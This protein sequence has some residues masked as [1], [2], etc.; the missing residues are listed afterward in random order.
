MK[1]K[2][3]RKQFNTSGFTLVEV[4]VA[5]VILLIISVPV[6]R[7]FATSAKTNGRSVLK[8]YATNAAEDIME[9]I[10]SMDIKTVVDTFS[11]HSLAYDGTAG[12][13]YDLV[14]DSA[15][16]CPYHGTAYDIDKCNICKAMEKDM[17]VK[18]SLDPTYY[19]NSNG[20][21]LGEY[22]AVSSDYSAIF[23]VPMGL[24]QDVFKEFEAKSQSF[25]SLQ[26][27]DEE[28][29]KHVK[30]ALWFSQNLKREI[31]IDVVSKGNF[32]T[33]DGKEYKKAMVDVRLSYL[34]PKAKNP[35]NDE[36]IKP[37][38]TTVE[39]IN[40]QIFTNEASEKPLNS[41]FIMYTPV[42]NADSNVR[43]DG[44]IIIV[45][46]NDNV[47][48]NLYIIAQDAARNELGETLKD[49]KGNNY[50]DAHWGEYIAGTTGL[51]L[52]IYENEI[53]DEVNGGTKQ[54][55]TLRTN[56]IEK[57][58]YKREDTSVQYPVLC[59]MNVGRNASDPEGPD[60]KFDNDVWKRIC[61]KKGQFKK[62]DD[63][64][65]VKAGALDGKSGDAS[66][67]TDRIY[68][69]SVTVANF[70]GTVADQE[71]SEQWP[72]SVTLTSSIR[73]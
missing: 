38:D 23:T 9:S 42:T 73:Q 51:N 26:Y 37:S 72:V 49:D 47:E 46:N 35:L 43:G 1:Q 39:K 20:I 52:Q 31:R 57:T 2:N 5:V 50:Y 19:E 11:I 36:V 56:L 16:G 54:P 29:A 18:I 21:N 14:L 25:C 68:D 40:R 12:Q 64:K 27:A 71:S 45:H 69:V 59:Y 67:I 62:V 17:A 7:A 13:K 15:T 60:D 28:V 8:S 10:K 22:D 3:N 44:D 4:L 6:L 48:A 32:T 34:L 61:N 41:I 58:D 65:S 24:D 70:S 30:D 66:T 63:A 53:A 33:E 55:L